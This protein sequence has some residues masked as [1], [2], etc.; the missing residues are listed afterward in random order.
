MWRREAPSSREQDVAGGAAARQQQRQLSPLGADVRLSTRAAP[1][2]PC[3][4]SGTRSQPR[5]RPRHRRTRRHAPACPCAPLPAG[6][7]RSIEGMHGAEGSKLQ[8]HLAGR[9]SSTPE[10][11]EGG[12][13]CI[14]MRHP[15]AGGQGQMQHAEALASTAAGEQETEQLERMAFASSWSGCCCGNAR[16]QRHAACDACPC[17]R[18]RSSSI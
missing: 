1:H 9:S 4:R 7:R 6:R 17:P 3:A 14:A 11:R 5:G 10:G 18:H 15:S 12:S 13:A 8:L 16:A 2:P